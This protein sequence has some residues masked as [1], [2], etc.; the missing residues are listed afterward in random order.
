MPQV[1]GA[2]LS[3]FASKQRLRA[4]QAIYVLFFSR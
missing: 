4:A 2:P 3:T 1:M